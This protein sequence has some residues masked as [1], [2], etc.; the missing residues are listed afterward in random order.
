MASTHTEERNLYQPGDEAHRKVLFTKTKFHVN[1]FA[2]ARAFA[3]HLQ[4]EF[5]FVCLVFACSSVS[6]QSLLLFFISS[7]EMH[8]RL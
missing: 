2:K 4:F 8:L 7:F 1:M 3:F 5:Y 6:V